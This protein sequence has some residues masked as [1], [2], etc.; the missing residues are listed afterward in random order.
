MAIR[1]YRAYLKFGAETLPAGQVVLF[2]TTPSRPITQNNNINS[3]AN[4]YHG[5]D[6]PLCTGHCLMTTGR[7]EC[8]AEVINQTIF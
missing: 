8:Y 5:T 1:P 6:F 7:Q 2:V 4:G 3:L